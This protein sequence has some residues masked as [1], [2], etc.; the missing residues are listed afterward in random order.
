MPG[1][2]FENGLT[3]QL[4]TSVT[5]MANVMADIA[6]GRE[7]ELQQQRN[8]H[9][10]R[11]TRARRMKPNQPAVKSATPSAIRIAGGSGADS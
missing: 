9:H 11:N 10:P 8:D 7:V 3:S 6:Q 5:P 4:M 2:Q 1:V